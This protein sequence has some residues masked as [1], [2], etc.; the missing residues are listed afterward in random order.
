MN[1]AIW[2]VGMRWQT[3]C[4]RQSH[5]FHCIVQK[6]VYAYTKLYSFMY[7]ILRW[8]CCRAVCVVVN[9]ILQAPMRIPKKTKENKIRLLLYLEKTSALRTQPMM[10][11]RWGT[12]LTYGKALVTR[13]FRL[14][15]CGKLGKKE[16]NW[17][18]IISKPFSILLII[19]CWMEMD[20]DYTFTLI[21]MWEHKNRFNRFLHLFHYTAHL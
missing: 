6:A 7:I 18:L 8:I 12:L 14:P 4:E 1:K 9:S 21:R 5:S 3:V 19:K 2:K 16:K 17:I 20:D 11:P 15:S 13:M 10:F